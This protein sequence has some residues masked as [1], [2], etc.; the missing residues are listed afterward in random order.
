VRGTNWTTPTK[1]GS[2]NGTTGLCMQPTGDSWR[3]ED[4]VLTEPTII[5]EWAPG[6]TNKDYQKAKVCRG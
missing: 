3:P 5:D 4:L 1:D 6:C 2:R